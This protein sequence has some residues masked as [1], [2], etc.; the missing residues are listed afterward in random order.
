MKRNH[1]A[2]FALVVGGAFALL[3]GAATE[4]AWAPTCSLVPE[5]R[6]VTV[7]QGLASYSR[8][9]RGKETLFRAYFGLP[10]CADIANGA[11]VQLIDAT[12][13]V[14][15][16]G[17]G[18][19]L[20]TISTSPSP[21]GPEFPRIT[22]AAGA[23]LP[24]DSAGDPKFVISGAA[25]APSPPDSSFTASFELAIR[26][27]PQ[28]TTSAALPTTASEQRYA[29]LTGSR[30]AITKV[31]EKRTNVLRI[32]AV[33]MGT[34][35]ATAPA[36]LQTGMTT[37]SRTFP[38]PD[39]TGSTLASGAP[40]PRT[41]DLF[42]TVGGI[43]YSP[44]PA[45]VDLSALLDSTGKF[46]GTSTN[47]NATAGVK[48]QLGG[49]LQSWNSTNRTAPAD[50]VVGGLDPSLAATGSTCELG[51]ASVSS[52]EA[53]TQ[54][55]PAR[56]GSLLGMEVCHTFG[57]VPSSRSDGGWHAI[58]PNADHL[59]GDANRAFNVTD[60]AFLADDRNAMR[61]STTWTDANTVFGRD[62]YAML[63]CKLGGATTTDCSTSAV[64]GTTEGAAASPA[65]ASFVMTGTTDGTAARTTVLES[66]KA[67]TLPTAAD[68]ASAYRL[69]QKGAGAELR[70]DGV[71]V[72]FADSFH[73]EASS[74]HSTEALGVFS[75]AFPLAAGATRVEL[76]APSGALLY[77]AAA[78][79]APQIGAAP[80]VVS[81]T[82]SVAT[83]PAG[84]AS[85]SET[86]SATTTSASPG[87]P[88]PGRPPSTPVVERKPSGG[89][90]ASSGGNAASSGGNVASSSEVSS[91]SWV[92]A[93]ASGITTASKDDAGASA[94]A[95]AITADAAN[96]T[97]ASFD[98]VPPQ[99][100]PNG[101]ADVQLNAFPTH[102]SSFGI[103]TTGD[104]QLADDANGSS[105][106]GADDAGGNVRGDNDLDVT[107]LRVNVTIPA[108][109]NCLSL[110]F[111]FLSEEFPEYVG[112]Q[113]NDGFVAELDS[114]T[115]TTSG[116][117]ISAPNNFA[118]DPSGNVVSVNSSGNTAMSAAH[119]AGTTYDGATPLLTAST[120][121]TPG[122]H[123][124]F[125]SIFDQGD[126][127]YDSAVFVDN[128]VVGTRTEAD[129][130]QGAKPVDPPNAQT[131]T[132]TASDGDTAASALRAGWFLDT[133]RP[134][135]PIYVLAVGDKPEVVGGVASFSL[136]TA[137]G[138]DGCTIQARVYD[139]FE[140]SPRT[141]VE[142]SS[143][144]TLSQPPSV[145]ISSPKPGAVILEHDPAVLQA[146]AYDFEGG[147]LGGGSFVWEAPC[148][149]SGTRTGH[150]I[151]VAP[152]GGGWTAPA[153][154]TVSVTATDGS[155]TSTTDT[156]TL[157]IRAD[158]DNDRTP[159]DKDKACNGASGDQNPLDFRG[160][161]DGDGKPNGQDEQRCVKAT[162]YEGFAL[163]VPS[164]FN[165]ASPPSTLGFEGVYVPYRALKDVPTSGVRISKIDGAAVPASAGLQA[166]V[167]KPVG[168]VG[169]AQIDGQKLAAYLIAHGLR[170]RAVTFTLRGDAATW[171]F[172]ATADAFVE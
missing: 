120:A 17:T 135:E 1:L 35:W 73:T 162:E 114:S 57:C 12:L 88:S 52:P 48:E 64:A 14:K 133:N 21:L 142:P 46:C 43:R 159:A 33:P 40:A 4:R 168:N 169:A 68:P 63:L 167:W 116:S 70:N 108:G 38:V 82:Q 25:L 86:S 103:L 151:T 148:L 51:R 95:N 37:L 23:T 77:Q 92:T 36:A 121:V 3:G 61:Y 111:K 94:I 45:G 115:W 124:L 117:T 58:Y 31:V 80:P 47:F 41:G 137:V 163:F 134:G 44:N 160:D 138:C 164:K 105:S 89:N 130:V 18:A 172:E 109:A 62:D 96:V 81:S 7:N 15:H 19:T 154:C 24:A 22:T 104:V 59:S 66:Y 5:L 106:S 91:A 29:T 102:G 27:K 119:A 6:A 76:V 161:D 145:A 156:E 107:V 153:S 128:L 112:R 42:S 93:A 131:A 28:A 84:T 136:T 99:G 129:C 20:A 34:T 83:Q 54:L 127:V 157:E 11:N 90:A 87:K 150:T 32:L 39:G 56:A 85:T 65:T 9:V 170:N 2:V 118:F 71:P 50:R 55:D 69:V 123:V 126:H 98:A 53:W 78:S 97:G 132:F 10:S 8:L 113:Y 146:T 141:D 49:I 158:A 122:Q 166:V 101:T 143:L 152:P 110:N 75:I 165:P 149:F 74:S 140:A 26:Y 100:A 72:S 144:D 139:G 60:R 67:E 79:A 30:T 155:G 13:T 147:F 171:Y 125:L 16:Q